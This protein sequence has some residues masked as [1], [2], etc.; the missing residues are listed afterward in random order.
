MPSWVPD[1]T[2]KSS[3]H[4]PAQHS[5]LMD[6]T[7]L[8]V[9]F[10][11]DYPLD[12]VLQVS[13]KRCGTVWTDTRV[14]SNTPTANDP[15]RIRSLSKDCIG[16]WLHAP[17]PDSREW[18]CPERLRFWDQVLS[19]YRAVYPQAGFE[20]NPDLFQADVPP[21]FG[22]PCKLCFRFCG[23]YDLNVRGRRKPGCYC[24]NCP[25]HYTKSELKDFLGNIS[26]Y[27]VG[28][29]IFGTDHSLGLGPL[30]LQDWD[31]VWMLEGSRVP[32]ILRQVDDHY[33]LVGAC[34][35]HAFDRKIHCCSACSGETIQQDI[36]SRPIR[37]PA[38]QANTTDII[39]DAMKPSQLYIV[40]ILRNIPQY[41][42]FTP[43][44]SSFWDPFLTPYRFSNRAPSSTPDVEVWMK[45]SPWVGWTQ[46][47]FPNEDTWFY[48][49]V[50]TTFTHLH[51]PTDSPL[52]GERQE[53]TIR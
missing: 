20:Y 13:G 12:C 48:W 53:I 10:S 21:S 41:P 33:R 28:R 35:V 40:K 36:T 11:R 27:G 5:M 26:R 23:G 49:E 17:S 29:R 50:A 44:R 30:E 2:R 8:Q 45:L 7:I 52:R 9:R 4:L 18:H 31:E 24:L 22:G 38:V 46:Y 42:S 14:F 3:A 1:W 47:T 43:Y 19:A 39:H 25:G 6:A 34:Y 51:P 15:Q 16:H 37:D 32:F